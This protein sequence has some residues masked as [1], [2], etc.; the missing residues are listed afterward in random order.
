[1][2]K[3]QADTATVLRLAQAMQDNVDPSLLLRLYRERMAAILSKAG[4]VVTV[5]PRD[6]SRLIIPGAE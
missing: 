5:D 3:A 2:A 6:D 1:L 4:A